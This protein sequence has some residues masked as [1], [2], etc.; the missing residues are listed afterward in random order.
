MP[1]NGLYADIFTKFWPGSTD[2]VFT[3]NLKNTGYLINIS[4]S[5][6]FTEM[7]TTV[8]PDILHILTGL[9]CEFNAFHRQPSFQ[10]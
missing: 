5:L 8:V 2:I 9:R 1:F 6:L 3:Q 10:P 7:A 4:V